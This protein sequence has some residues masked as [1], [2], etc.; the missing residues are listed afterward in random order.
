MKRREFLAWTGSASLALAVHDV[1]AATNPIRVMVGYPPGGSVDLQGRIAAAFLAQSIGRPTVV[2]NKPGASGRIAVEFVKGAAPD[3]DTLLVCPQGPMTL[4]PYVFK[5]LRYDPAT[6]FA[7]IARMGVSDLA[8]SIG[9]MVP[10]KDF[11]GLR[12]W[13]KSSNGRPEFGSPGAGTIVHFAGV[14]AS[15]KMGIKLSH[16]PYQGSAKS[17]IDLAGGNIGMVISPVTEALELHK[18]GRIRMIATFGPRRSAYVPDIPTF[19]E[20]GYDLE[21][22]GWNAVY[23]PAKLA[24]PIVS[25][26][27]S[28]I[29]AGLG[30]KDIKQQ[31]EAQG[32]QPAFLGPEELE[33]ARVKEARLWQ[34][35]VRSSGFTPEG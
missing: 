35:V 17:M 34:D 2:E 30:Q 13:L 19:R 3:G 14:A 20:L 21:V 18:A 29:E 27:R 32:V 6:D 1:H 33:A 10:A 12:D 4:F 7:P 23:G 11:A 5:N 22:Q 15:Q 31:M 8:L 24:P 28:A 26:Y 25:A 9:P 16:V